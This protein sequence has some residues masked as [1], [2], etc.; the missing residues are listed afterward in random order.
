LIGVM[1]LRPGDA[2]PRPAAPIVI[3]APVPIAIATPRPAPVMLPTV[4]AAV[5]APALPDCPIPPLAD[6]AP[7]GRAVTP[8][9][10]P[11]DLGDP[12]TGE[13]NA[14]EV[15]ASPRVAVIAIVD[16]STGAAYASHDDGRRFRAVFRGAHVD[17]IAVDDRGRVYALGERLFV[18]EP[19]GRERAVEL[20]CAHELCKDRIVAVPGG[21]AWIHDDEIRLS[22]DGAR[23]WRTL[24]RD[25]GAAVAGNDR[26]FASGGALYGVTH[27]EEDCGWD[28][29]QIDRVD[30]A[31]GAYRHDTFNDD[32][33][34]RPRVDEVDLGGGTWRYRPHRPIAPARV[35]SLVLASV[36]P[37]IGGRAL[38]VE[39]G[40]LVEVCGLRGRELAHGFL[41]THV[42][43]V[44]A[45]GRPLV[46][47]GEALLRWSPTYG[48]RVL[49]ERQRVTDS[50]TP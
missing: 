6:D 19:D 9:E 40:T 45:A 11:G 43:A 38:Q 23:T 29:D 20:T 37:V 31:T 21:V 41:A 39:R 2:P 26:L 16:R 8:A 48:W 34:G 25:D 35:P 3:R 18:R 14:F 30:L 49:F 50:A 1:A 32:E 24:D 12:D 13:A 46:S 4:V 44:D 15:A 27:V 17:A 42:D 47:H 28:A 22:V 7:I 5:P 36:A 33:V 10:T